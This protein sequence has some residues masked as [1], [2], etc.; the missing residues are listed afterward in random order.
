MVNFLCQ[1]NHLKTPRLNI[2]SIS[3]RVFPNEITLELVDSVK[4]IILQNKSSVQFSCLVMSYPLQP[5][6]LQ[7]TRLSCPSQTPRAYSNSCPLSWW[8]LPTISSFVISFTSC[9]QSFPAS[10]SFPMSQCFTSDGQSWSFSFHISP[11]TEHP[12]LISFRMDWLD[13]LA[14]QG[15]LKSLLQHHSSKHQFFG[16]RLSLWSNSHIHTWLLEKP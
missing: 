9:L 3:G 10:G 8:W 15:T 4:L 14:V 7:H 1:P 6:G 12:G 16:A 11:S 5:H 2:S 13:L